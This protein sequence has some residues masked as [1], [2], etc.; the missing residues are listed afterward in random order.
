MLKKLRLVAS[1]LDYS[2]FLFSN[3]NNKLSEK[4]IILL[5]LNMQERKPDVYPKETSGSL[6]DPRLEIK[7]SRD[8]KDESGTPQTNKNAG[9]TPEKTRLSKDHRDS[10]RRRYHEDPRR[11]H[12][13]SNGSE[14]RRR[15]RRER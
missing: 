13:R 10:D 4:C 3:C 8:D 2:L 5:L 9:H 7:S 11:A 15:D 12:S 14:R 6:R 1:S